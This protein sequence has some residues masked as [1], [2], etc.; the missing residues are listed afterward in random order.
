MRTNYVDG[1][2]IKYL[3][4]DAD[5]AKLI[6]D[7]CRKTV[8]INKEKWGVVAP[9]DCQVYVMRSWQWYLWNAAPP[10]WK[11]LLV[12]TFPFWYF[13]VRKIWPIAG[14]WE[15]QFGKRHTIGVKTPQ[16]LE[17]SDRSH[18]AQIFVP[19]SGTEQKV[20]HITCHELTHAFVSAN[21]LPNWLKEGLSMLAVDYYAG[22][23]T[24]QQGTLE[25]LKDYSG[26]FNSEL[27]RRINIRDQEAIIYLYTRGYWVTRYLDEVYPDLLPELLAERKSQDQLEGGIA[28]RL[29]MSRVQFWNQIDGI[30]IEHY[31]D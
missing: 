21:L 12:L 28:D 31:S 18:G 25:S 26:M 10:L 22:H 2:I 16:V 20:E 3:D 19:E 13:R 7:T 15:Q 17:A 5:A 24:V 27:E 8:Q 14:G 11:V 6:I 30:V 29:G 23:Q 9:K 4:Q 1:I